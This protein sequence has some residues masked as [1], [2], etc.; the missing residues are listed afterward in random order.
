MQNIV[1]NDD[2]IVHFST[3]YYR[4]HS[5]PGITGISPVRYASG[6]LHD[7]EKNDGGIPIHFYSK[8]GVSTTFAGE[9]GQGAGFT[10]TPATR[11]DIPIAP[12]END[13]S[14]IFYVAGSNLTNNTLSNVTLGTQ[15]LNV[16]QNKMGT[17]DATTYRL[18]DI[19]GGVVLL[20][21]GD[22]YLTFDQNETNKYDLHYKSSFR[23]DD[24]KWCME[25]N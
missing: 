25:P 22:N 13:A 17:G 14:T 6:Y 16:I 24:V 12:T 19:G 20:L 5:Q 23:I 1:Y 3:G 4:L 10:E 21:S 15:G 7:I 9:D 2:N 11:G 18:I 8:Q